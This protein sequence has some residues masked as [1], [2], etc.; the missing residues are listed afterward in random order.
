MLEGQTAIVT[1]GAAGIGGGITRRFA[2]A[3][4]TVARLLA[5]QNGG[6]ARWTPRDYI[7]LAREERQT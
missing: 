3:G 4:A 7:G 1:G 5:F 6:V 2:A